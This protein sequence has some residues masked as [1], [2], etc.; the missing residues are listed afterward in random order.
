MSGFDTA[1]AF[2]QR[3]EGGWVDAHGAALTLHLEA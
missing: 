3:W 1:L 2:V